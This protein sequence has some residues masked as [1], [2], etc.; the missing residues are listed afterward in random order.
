MSKVL[1]Q[2]YLENQDFLEEAWTEHI[3]AGEWGS[4]E[5]RLNITDDMFWEWVE[6]QHDA[7]VQSK[8]NYRKFVEGYKKFYF[9]GGFVVDLALVMAFFIWILN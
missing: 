9:N 7:Q 8:P 4:G 6:E 3:V 5:D 2:F 1:E